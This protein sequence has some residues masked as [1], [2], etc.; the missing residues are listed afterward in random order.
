M[1]TLGFHEGVDDVEIRFLL[2]LELLGHHDIPV[3]NGLAGQLGYEPLNRGGMLED[4]QLAHVIQ[5]TIDSSPAFVKLL[6]LGG[7][8]DSTL[9]VLEVVEMSYSFRRQLT[10]LAILV[11]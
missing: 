8:C 1:L 3:T 2:D 6:E 7:F 5:I 11:I 9:A 4:L 10:V